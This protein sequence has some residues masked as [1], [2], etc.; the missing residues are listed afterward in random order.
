MI[1]GCNWLCEL[2]IMVPICKISRWKSTKMVFGRM[3]LGDPTL[4]YLLF[5]SKKIWS[6][7]KKWKW[8][9]FN[10]QWDAYTRAGYRRTRQA[11]TRVVKT[12]VRRGILSQAQLPTSS[13]V[14][15]LHYSTKKS[16][17]LQEGPNPPNVRPYC[18]PRRQK[19]EIEKVCFTKWLMP[20]TF[21]PV[22]AHISIQYC[23]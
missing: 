1:L 9:L 5:P 12:R 4:S 17:T 22:K 14:G 20:V 11:R 18:Y 13:P 15:S 8:A 7:D 2:G 16:I 10:R 6:L 3:L 19:T 21:Y 23:W